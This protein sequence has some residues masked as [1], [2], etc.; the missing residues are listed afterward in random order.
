MGSARTFAGLAGFSHDTLRRLEMVRWG[1]APEDWMRP[2]DRR[3]LDAFVN[4]G[5]LQP[6]DDWWQRFMIAFSWQHLVL[7]YGREAYRPETLFEPVVQEHVL[8]LIRA[9][10]Q[11]E[12]RRRTAQG[13]VLTE[14]GQ[15]QLVEGI[16]G[17]VILRLSATGLVHAQEKGGRML[18]G[19]D[20]TR[21]LEGLLGTGAQ[22]DTPYLRTLRLAYDW[23]EEA[24]VRRLGHG[25]DGA[26]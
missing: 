1:T 8:A 2:V 15:E 14:E 17:E 3:D 21:S 16:V 20:Q 24:I 23:A 4:A 12:F 5:F 22:A 19:I 10:V 7:R 6:E 26:P 11:R 25:G 18:P 9:L 13:A